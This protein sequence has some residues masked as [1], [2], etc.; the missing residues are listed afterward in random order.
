MRRVPGRVM[1]TVALLLVG[2]TGCGGDTPPSSAAASSTAV[3]STAVSSTAA[4][5]TAASSTGTHGATPNLDASLGIGASVAQYRRDEAVGVVQ[6]KAVAGPD[7]PPS[8]VTSAQLRWD[9]M[10]PVPPVE[11]DTAL[12]SGRRVDLPAPLGAAAC[13]PLGDV[14]PGDSPSAPPLGDGVIRLTLDA[15]GERR[16]VTRTVDAPLLPSAEAPL[17]RI[18]EHDCQRQSMRRAVE[19]GL[20]SRWRR[21]DTG[22]I[23]TAEGTLVLTR[24]ATDQPIS[25]TSVNGSV[26]LNLSLADGDPPTMAPGQ[27]RLE[28]P[29]RVTSSG[30]CD[31]HALGGSSQ[32]YTL[33]AGIEIGGDGDPIGVTVSPDDD[34]RALFAR[35]I[36]DAC[37]HS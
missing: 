35:V 18:F 17:R 5:S 8:L 24:G 32:T 14:A 25:I 3:S 10:T 33:Q 20:S 6:L 16:G 12:T 29:V 21:S 13:G 26:L 30:R 27:E 15:P 19:V 37:D 4:S 34:G 23:P 9:G 28:V 1:V 2:A 11:V 7:T 36:A 31:G 22:G